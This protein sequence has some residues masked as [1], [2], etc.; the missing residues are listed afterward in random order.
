MGRGPHQPEETDHGADPAVPQATATEA[1][2]AQARTE[3]IAEMG[4]TDAKASALLTVLSLPL[5]VLI[6]AVPGHDLPVAA[7]VTAGIGAATLAAAML[8]VLRIVRRTGQRLLPPLG[9]LHAPRG[10]H[11]HRRQPQR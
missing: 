11:R 1:R 3:V 10:R 7:T 5:A 8:L 2:L 9:D 4:R 6:A